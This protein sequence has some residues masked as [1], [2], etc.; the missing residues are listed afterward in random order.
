[1]KARTEVAMVTNRLSAKE[2]VNCA[3]YLVAEPHD[4]DTY[5]QR[6]GGI[7]TNSSFQN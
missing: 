6:N 2:Q 7:R 5:L 4:G 3:G 1:M